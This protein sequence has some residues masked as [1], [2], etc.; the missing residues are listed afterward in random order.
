MFDGKEI[1]WKGREGFLG[2]G[3]SRSTYYLQELL[4]SLKKGRKGES[5]VVK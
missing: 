3:C 1:Q 2:R 4:V 5:E